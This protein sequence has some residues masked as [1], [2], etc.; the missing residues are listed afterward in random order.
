MADSAFTIQQRERKTLINDLGRF[1]GFSFRHQSAI[2]RILT[3]EEVVNWDHDNNGEAEFW[4]DGDHCGVS[5]VF[6]G[7]CTAA[8]I[9]WLD[10]LID[11]LGDN[12]ESF[13]KV[14]WFMNNG[15]DMS[16]M[17]A[18]QIEDEML[19]VFHGDCFIDI[20]KE[21]AFELFETWF[22]EEYAVWEKSLCPGLD[23]DPERF[24]AGPEL[25]T[26]SVTIGTE[27]FLVVQSL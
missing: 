9:V 10:E 25:S 17:T 14:A 5:A 24:L 7:N 12:T 11:A 18:D 23:F 8:D 13:V 20:E 26:T 22:P 21:A 6:N 16:T 2:S 19:Y 1:E 15:Y 3:A 4:P 27:K